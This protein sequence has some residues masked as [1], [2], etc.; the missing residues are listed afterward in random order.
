MLSPFPALSIEMSQTLRAVASL[1]T[2]SSLT[3]VPS[4]QESRAWKLPP[5]SAA[6][7]AVTDQY[8]SGSNCSISASRLTISLS[9]T[10]WTRPAERAPGSF[11]HK[12]GVSMRCGRSKLE[13]LSTT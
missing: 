9:A 6:S 7:A 5:C 13:P 1:K 10:D 12:I 4:K 8:S 2:S 11:R 3:F